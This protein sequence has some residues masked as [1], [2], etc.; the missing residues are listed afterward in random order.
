MRANAEKEA[1]QLGASTKLDAETK[2][3]EASL[4][5]ERNRAKAGL[6]LANAEGVVALCL[7]KKNAHATN[8]KRVDVYRKL[9]QNRKLI[10]CDSENDDANLL[11]VANAILSDASA[12]GGQALYR[13]A[14]MVQL[15]LMHRGLS[16]LFMNAD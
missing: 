3:V 15:S 10:L 1:S 16:G 13:S 5:A 12:N 2:L 8:M 11:V 7:A 9:A 6:V 4:T 14:V